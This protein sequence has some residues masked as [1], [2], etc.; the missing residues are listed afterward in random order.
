MM[1]NSVRSRLTAWYAGVLSCSLLLLSLVIYF[2]V[3]QSVLA[4]VDA[5]MH[6]AA[7]AY[8]GESVENPRKYFRNNVVAAL[9]LLN[10]AMDAGRLTILC[11]GGVLVASGDI[12]VGTL[13]AFLSSQFEHEVLP[14]TR[15]RCSLTG[16]FRRREG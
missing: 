12:T 10:R 14:A 8:V 16:W 6:F 5:V 3:K 9:T 4:R 1:F 2:I 7:H 11:Y 15:E 13:V